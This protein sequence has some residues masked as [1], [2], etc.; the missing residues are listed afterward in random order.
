MEDIAT[1]PWDRGDYP[2]L[3]D[4]LA[5]AASTIAEAAGVGKGRSAIDVAAG[6][7]SVARRLAAAGWSTTA[8]DLAAAM[9]ARGAQDASADDVRIRWEQADLADQP[10]PDASQHL[11][12]SSFGMIFASEPGAAVAEAARVLAPDGRLLLTAWTEDGY[13]AQMGGV[14]QQHL[15]APAGPAERPMAWGDRSAVAELLDPSFT[16]VEIETRSLPWEFPSAAWAREWLEQSSPAHIA[17]MAAAGDAEAMMTA[18]EEH[19]A[20]YADSSGRVSV[21]A[22][23]LLVR[24]RVRP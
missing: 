14:I 8:T 22:E 2:A 1:N 24:A 3:A 11:V 20:G 5:P 17:A 10:V 6:T 13:M 15:P 16:D 23:Y 4:R 19:L 7:G 9:V 18:V 21:A 12:T